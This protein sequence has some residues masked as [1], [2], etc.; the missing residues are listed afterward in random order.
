MAEYVRRPA[1]RFLQTIHAVLVNVVYD[2]GKPTYRPTATT[3]LREEVATRRPVRNGG[4][5]IQSRVPGARGVLAQ[6]HGW[7]PSGCVGR[8]TLPPWADGCAY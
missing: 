8:S 7:Q 4:E 1:S 3:C 2:D 5:S 6:R